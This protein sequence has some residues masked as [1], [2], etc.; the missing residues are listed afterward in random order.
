MDAASVLA[1]ALSPLLA[2]CCFLPRG[3]E[4]LL[5]PSLRTQ[6]TSRG[7]GPCSRGR[8]ASC[9]CTLLQ[10]LAVRPSRLGSSRPPAGLA[11]PAQEPVVWCPGREA[12]KFSG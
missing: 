2:S 3:P 9:G 5:Q 11:T 6:Q 1:H 10:R 7:Q 12:V 8:V 4:W